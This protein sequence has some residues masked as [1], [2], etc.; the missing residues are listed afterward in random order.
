MNSDEGVGEAT[1]TTDPGPISHRLVQRTPIERMLSEHLWDEVVLVEAR[2]NVLSEEVRAL[3]ERRDRL[4]NIAAAANIVG[5]DF[6]T[7]V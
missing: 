5:P 1:I 3:Y 4:V 7:R 2:I 6:G